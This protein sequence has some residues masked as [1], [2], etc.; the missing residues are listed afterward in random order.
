M[1]LLCVAILAVLLSFPVHG[2]QIRKANEA[3][4]NRAYCIQLNG[5]MEAAYKQRNSKVRVDCLTSSH[6]IEVDWSD[7]WAESIG[8][9][10]NY[11]ILTRRN[12]GVILICRRTERTCA[13]HIQRMKV[14]VRVHRLPIDVWFCEK[15]NFAIDQCNFDSKG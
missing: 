14:T 15:D 11:A 13:N 10:L 3:D 8:Q 9:S 2:Q 12:A 4:Y 6:A 1:R 7:K 5:A